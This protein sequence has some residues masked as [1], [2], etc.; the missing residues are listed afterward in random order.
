MRSKRGQLARAMIYA[1]ALVVLIA[2]IYTT[3]T[4]VI[5]NFKDTSLLPQNSMFQ[6]TMS[7]VFQS[8]AKWPLVAII[9]IVIII[10]MYAS[11]GGPRRRT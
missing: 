4:P 2:I 8:W 10:I 7:L 11:T 3:F 5:Q 1:M 6:D 9:G